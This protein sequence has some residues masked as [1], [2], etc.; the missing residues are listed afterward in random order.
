MYLNSG[1]NYYI[2][3]LENRDILTVDGYRVNSPNFKVRLLSYS[4]LNKIEIMKQSA[5]SVFDTNEEIF[6]CCV[7]GILGYEGIE[8]DF[9]AHGIVIDSIA[10]KVYEE[11]IKAIQDPVESF[12]TALDKMGAFDMWAGHVS[13]ILHINYIE[14]LKLP[15]AE[16][17]RLYAIAYLV[18]GQT[19]PAIAIQEKTESKV[20]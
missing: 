14:V 13:S 2:I 16:V 10:S 17:L 20:G 9:H 7:L 5:M 18:S 19:I 4:E 1:S 15:A 3:P 8:F 6:N 12:N 11:S